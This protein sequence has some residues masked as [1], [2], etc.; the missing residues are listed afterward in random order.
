MAEVFG[1]RDDFAIE[2]GIEPELKPPSAVWG[3]MCICGLLS[4]V[5]GELTI[6]R[7]WA[8]EFVSLDDLAV[9]NFLD[10]LLYGYHGNL[11]LPDDRPVA[12]LKRGAVVW[13][14]FNFLTNWGEQFDRC[15][16]FIMCPPGGPVRIL[17]RDLP[18]PLA[19]GVRVSKEGVV[20][21]INGFT[22]WFEKQEQRL[23]S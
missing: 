12:T 6:D 5:H 14:C 22:E 16:A 3:H 17:S 20:A 13:G 4:P 7:L 18:D 8:E 19:P 10:G 2:A 23:K 9:L 1:N 11:E 21:A 15:K